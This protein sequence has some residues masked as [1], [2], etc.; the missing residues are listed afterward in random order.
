MRLK[1]AVVFLSSR[2]TLSVDLQVGEARSRCW[3]TTT[4]PVADVPAE[5]AHATWVAGVWQTPG[6]ANLLQV[7]LGV[8]FEKD[9]E[10]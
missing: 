10:P 9:G 5:A 3:P 4:F 2:L 7:N 8:G 6:N 1:D